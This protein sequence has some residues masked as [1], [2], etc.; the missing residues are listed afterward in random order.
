MKAQ[1]K[2]RPF[3]DLLVGIVIPSVVLMKLS[4]PEHLGPTWALVAA[5]SFPIGLALYE[6]LRYRATNYVA[7]LGLVSVLLTGGIG[8][9][10]L[11]PKWLAV[12]EAAIPALI[13]TAVLVSGWLGFPL[14]RTLLYNPA[15]LDTEKIAARLRESGHEETFEARLTRSNYL[16]A[17]TFVFSATMN[18]LLATWIVTSPTGSVAFNEELGR[19]TL[20]SYPVIAVPCMAMMLTIIYFLWRSVHSLTGLSLEEALAPAAA[21]KAEEGAGSS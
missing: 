14:V 20:L 7:I 15:V 6:M 11:D 5:L 19:M 18:Y 21:A 1:R 16:L 2:P 10:E 4:G 12:K 3:F 13:G 17:G 9:I 8:L